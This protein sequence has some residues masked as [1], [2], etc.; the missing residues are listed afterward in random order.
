MFKIKSAKTQ[1][2]ALATAGTVALSSVLGSG[3]ALANPMNLVPNPSFESVNFS[4]SGPNIL[5]WAKESKGTSA[6]IGLTKFATDGK[7][8]VY[9]YASK[10]ANK[11]WPGFTTENIIPVDPTKEYTFSASYYAPGNL[12]GYYPGIPW[13]DM[14]L[15]DAA[16]KRLG[17]VSTGSS[18][19]QVINEWHEKTYTFKPKALKK[20][21]PDIAGVKLGLRL[22]LNY[23]VTGIEAGKLTLLA[24]DNVKFEVA[25][26]DVPGMGASEVS[27]PDLVVSIDIP[28]TVLSLDDQKVFHNATGMS[29][30]VKNVGTSDATGPIK[31]K[32]VNMTKNGVPWNNGG[33]FQLPGDSLLSPGEEATLTYYPG[34]G[35]SWEPG[36][37]TMQVKVDPIYYMPGGKSFPDGHI[38]ELNESNNLSQVV[39]FQIVP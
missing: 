8:A 31:A 28:K 3:M 20:Y 21:F 12:P 38:D 36:F 13:M 30:T 10:S 14:T 23:G 9:V 6:K 22:S 34:V 17:A 7:Y 25:E 1:V 5:G 19:N 39:K 27:K 15:F 33:S 26:S 2:V 37:Y 16:G 32:K 24:Y 11:G 35:A 18:S 29:I 4:A